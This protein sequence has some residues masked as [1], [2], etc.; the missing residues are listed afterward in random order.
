MLNLKGLSFVGLLYLVFKG[1]VVIRASLSVT[2]CS[3]I[4]RIELTFT[5]YNVGLEQVNEED[6]I[7]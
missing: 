4:F 1:E 3:N 5:S 6:L 7:S 2:D